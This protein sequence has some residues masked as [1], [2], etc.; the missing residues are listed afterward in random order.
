MKHINKYVDLAAYT[1][2]ASRSTTLS[3]VSHV[4]DGTG[5]LYN[6]KNILADKESAEFADVA[7]FDKVTNTQRVIKRGTYDAATLPASIVVCGVVLGRRGSLV[8]AAAKD[9]A[10]KQW[11]EPYQVK[12][13]GFDF[14]TGGSFTLTVNST[15]TGVIT[16]LTGSGENLT[17]TAVKI[18]AALEAAGFTAATG[19]SCTAGADHILVKQNWYTPN[20]TT[21]TVTDADAKVTRTILTGNYQTSLAATVTPGIGI[22]PFGDISRNDGSSSYYAGANLGKFQLYYST[23]GTT[24]INQPLGAVSI[25]KEANFTAELNPILVAYYKTYQNYIMSKMVRFPWSKKAILSNNGKLNT[26][27]LAAITYTKADGTTGYGYPAAAY[28]KQYGITTAGYT[29]GFEAGNW[30]CPSVEELY[31]LIKNITMGLPGITTANCD[32]FNQS[33]SKIG[34][35][36]VQVTNYIWAS[37]EFS[38]TSAWNFIGSNGNMFNNNK[39]NSFSVRPFI[40]F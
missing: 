5:L 9:A 25:I 39:D 40:A 22:T 1:A 13:T 10:D 11:A 14:A 29:T 33:M 30:F 37:S 28:A 3:S 38:S 31:M 24:D 19:W 36:L 23:N 15:V 4:A 27:K 32:L 7:V 18:M 35:T 6:G 16:Y 20:V 17:T 8:Y 12:L 34:G 26:A 21:F 2:D